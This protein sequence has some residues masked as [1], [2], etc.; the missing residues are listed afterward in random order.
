MTQTYVD[1]AI[2]AYRR[3]GALDQPS[4]ESDTVTVKGV[5]YI[6]LYNVRGLLGVYRVTPLDR[7]HALPFDRIPKEIAAA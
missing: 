7:I 2:A 6:R 5:T 4:A 1:R 3:S